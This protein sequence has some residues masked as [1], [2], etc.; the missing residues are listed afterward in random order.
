M[1]LKG[2]SEEEISKALEVASAAEAVFQSGF[3]KASSVSML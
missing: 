2:H 3:T 1:R